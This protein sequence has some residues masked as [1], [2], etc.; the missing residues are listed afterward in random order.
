VTIDVY[1]HARADSAVEALL[2]ELLDREWQAQS[3]RMAPLGMTA[4]VRESVEL[5]FAGTPHGIF[6]VAPE[7]RHAAASPQELLDRVRDRMPAD[8][9]PWTLRALRRVG[10]LRPP[11][12]LL[13]PPEAPP[14]AALEPPLPDVLESPLERPVA[15][16]PV[17]APVMGESRPSR[18]PRA[19]AAA[20]ACG[21]LAGAPIGLLDV[22][23]HPH[24]AAVGAVVGA[25][26]A[27]LGA[28]VAVRARV[29]S[30]AG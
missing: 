8:L 7:L 30:A 12:P 2:A 9:A 13:A 21:A 25:L 10:A 27:A 11:Q 22:G 14:P 18:R 16:E 4:P 26:A 19:I 24:G 5:V 29:G 28:A 6:A 15:V 3:A 1:T 23:L 20:G 17:V